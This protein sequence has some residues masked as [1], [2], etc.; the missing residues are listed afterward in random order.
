MI[1][2]SSTE[3][4]MQCLTCKGK[5]TFTCWGTEVPYVC[6]CGG[7]LVVRDRQIPE[8]ARVYTSD[9]SVILRELGEL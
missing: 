5:F 3:W 1:S 8:P 4:K 9:P 7:F 6:A 2:V